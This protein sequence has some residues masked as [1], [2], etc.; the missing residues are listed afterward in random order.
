[1]EE[2]KTIQDNLSKAYEM[3]QNLDVKPTKTNMETILFALDAI[4]TAYDAMV[5]KQEDDAVL[6]RYRLEE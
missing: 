2:I 5:K 1:M 4:K 3:L 6:E